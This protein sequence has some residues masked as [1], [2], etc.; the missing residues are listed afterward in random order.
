MNYAHNID[1]LPLSEQQALALF[2]RSF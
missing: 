2:V 1:R